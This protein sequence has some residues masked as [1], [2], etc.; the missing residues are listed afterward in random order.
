[1]KLLIDMNLSPDWV[2]VFKQQG[3]QAL[4][5]STVGNP[6]ATD[7]V[8]ME[9]ARAN[10]YVVFT[11]DLDFETLLA[12]TLVQGPSVIQVRIQD[13]MPQSLG[14]RLVQILRQYEPALEKG[15][16]VTVDEIRSRVRILPFRQG[17]HV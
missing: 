6:R 17:H 16:L 14:S 9:W 3:W 1:M 2:A 15:A 11:H 10:G 7:S 13:I 12:T 8:I 4:H 5:W